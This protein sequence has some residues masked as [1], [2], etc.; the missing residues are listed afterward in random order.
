M[1]DPN[2]V[3][4][5]ASSSGWNAAAAAGA[6]S[7]VTR[8]S[9]GPISPDPYAHARQAA[10]TPMQ[11]RAAAEPLR[12]MRS[13]CVG[14]D[15]FGRRINCFIR[16]SPSQTAIEHVVEALLR[17]GGFRGP[18]LTARTGLPGTYLYQR[19]D[20]ALMKIYANPAESRA[21]P[22]YIATRQAPTARVVHPPQNSL[23]KQQAKSQG[24][25]RSAESFE[26]V[27]TPGGE[28]DYEVHT[29]PHFVDQWLEVPIGSTSGRQLQTHRYAFRDLVRGGGQHALQISEVADLPVWLPE[30]GAVV[31]AGSAG[32][33]QARRLVDCYAVADKYWLF[34]AALPTGGVI[35]AHGL[36]SAAFPLRKRLVIEFECLNRQINTAEHPLFQQDLSPASSHLNADDDHHGIEVNSP[37]ATREDEILQWHAG[38]NTPGMVSD[39]LLT[40]LGMPP[41]GVLSEVEERYQDHLFATHNWKELAAL[42]ALETGRDVILVRKG[43]AGRASLSDLISELDACGLLPDGYRLRVSA[44]RASSPPDN[45]MVYGA[46]NNLPRGSAPLATLRLPIQ[47]ASA[48]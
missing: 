7:N 28:H 44:C 21:S 17:W 16:L 25:I 6:A 9:G 3:S 23:E 22:E 32:G 18:W 42:H 40:K 12:I 37:L 47:P 13:G 34:R 4:S 39:V 30:S 24:L 43:A 36:M 11:A 48:G 35:S 27:A 26:Q 5:L 20:P 46:G 29:H 38:S 15:I 33:L 45:D 41:P 19:L 1:W 8:T 10:V 2:P 31:R 14:K